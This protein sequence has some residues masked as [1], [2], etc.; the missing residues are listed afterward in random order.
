MLNYNKIHSSINKERT[1]LVALSKYLGIANS[2]FIDRLKKQNLLPDD[3]EK[4][5]DFFGKSIDYYFDRDDEAKP[6]KA[7]NYNQQP[8]PTLI[9]DEYK[10][11]RLCKEKDKQIE[12]MEKYIAMLEGKGPNQKA[13]SG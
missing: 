8:K 13:T 6:V 3:I 10:T 9:S 11:C 1:P 4:I 5:A 2:T 12:I 7:P